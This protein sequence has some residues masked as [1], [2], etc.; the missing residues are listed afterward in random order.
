MIKKILLGLGMLSQLLFSQ[1]KIDNFDFYDKISKGWSL[2]NYKVDNDPDCEKFKPIFEKVDIDSVKTYETDFITNDNKKSTSTKWRDQKKECSNF[3]QEHSLSA[4][5]NLVLFKDG[6]RINQLYG[7]PLEEVVE[8][9]VKNTIEAYNKKDKVKVKEQGKGKV[10]I[11]PDWQTAVFEMSL[12]DN[13]N[14]W[15]ILLKNHHLTDLFLKAYD[16]DTVIVK[17][18]TP[19]NH[20]DENKILKCLYASL[21]QENA[22][23]T[24]ALFPQNHLLKEGLEKR[25]DK[26]GVVIAD[27][28]DK[29]TMIGGLALAAHHKQ[30][31]LFVNRGLY[32]TDKL[33]SENQAKK[34]R[35]QILKKLESEGINYKGIDKENNNNI[36]FLTVACDV[37]FAFKGKYYFM[38]YKYA[39]DN[40]LIRDRY[41]KKWGIHGR[42]T[43]KESLYQAMGSMFLKEKKALFFD[44]IWRSIYHSHHSDNGAEFAKS[45]MDIS[46]LIRPDCTEENLMEELK[47]NPDLVFF[48]SRGTPN[49]YTVYRNKNIVEKLYDHLTFSQKTLFDN[50]GRGDVSSLTL[51]HPCIFLA[52]PHSYAGANPY[53]AHTIGGKVL[54]TGALI[55]SGAV[56]EPDRS[57]FNTPTDIFIALLNGA[58]YAE[59]L[60]NRD[61][62]KG[63]YFNPRSA[64][65]P[66]F[67]ID[68][69]PN[70]T[71]YSRVIFVGDPLK[72]L[73]LE[74]KQ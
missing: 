47:K 36:D 31:L 70:G 3:V 60:Q 65:E 48:Q 18:K 34:F 54:R 21:G 13:E 43:G 1:E 73:D 57:A 9:W 14:K 24:E 10:V 46:R 30:Q 61:V 32:T 50:D 45:F 15:P 40:L 16:E 23:N 11:V 56:S 55:F 4:S 42:L 35:E 2:V 62:T 49:G 22:Y 5:P 29:Y 51:S 17:E 28:E 7:T 27:F 52:N 67:Y 58:T 12:W 74:D 38:D 53:D 64:V 6:K 68:A 66:F 8:N 37:S 72:K 44:A 25:L 69:K 63:S 26:K 41:G 59:A 39:V 19:L 20:L 71:D 33:I